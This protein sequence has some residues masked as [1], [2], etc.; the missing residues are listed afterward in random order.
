MITNNQA[1]NNS[2]S[3]IVGTGTLNRIDSN[4]V[5]KNG[6]LGIHGTSD[7]VIRNTASGNTGGNY[8]DT[9]ANVA[10]VQ[11]ANSATNPFANF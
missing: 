1:C 4:L 7:W 2:A 6:G 11:T 10:P 9:G 5:N 8:S 3:G